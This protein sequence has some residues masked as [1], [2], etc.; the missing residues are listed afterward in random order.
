MG[1]GG[2]GRRVPHQGKKSEAIE[3]GTVEGR[4]DMVATRRRCCPIKGRGVGE[5]RQRL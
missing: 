5:S 3:V 1:S 4:P 2:P